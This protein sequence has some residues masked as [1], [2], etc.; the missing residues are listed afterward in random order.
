M[1][2]RALPVGTCSFV[3]CPQWR[4]I[5]AETSNKFL[6]HLHTLCIMVFLKKRHAMHFPC[7]LHYIYAYQ[8][9]ASYCLDNIPTFLDTKNIYGEV[10]S[11]KICIFC[12]SKLQFLFPLDINSLDSPEYRS[13]CKAVRHLKSKSD[14]N[15][16]MS[17]FIQKLLFTS[18]S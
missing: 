18:F 10:V 3:G 9:V 17:C 4:G 8:K 13:R 2:H 7:K 16:G 6:M 1:G 5:E 11:L 15:K 12:S 14:F